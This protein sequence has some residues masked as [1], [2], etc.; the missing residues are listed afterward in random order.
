MSK[1]LEALKWLMDNGYVKYENSWQESPYILENINTIEKE[2]EEHEQHKAIEEEQG[3][4]LAALSKAING[5]KHRCVYNVEEKCYVFVNTI[6]F[7]GNDLIIKGYAENSVFL[8]K[9]YGKTWVL[10]KEARENV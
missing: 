1:G 6:I 5:I 9:E 4:G 8:V 7:Y 10:T 3:I 2:L